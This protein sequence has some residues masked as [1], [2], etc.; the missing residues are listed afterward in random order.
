MELLRVE[1]LTKRY[2]GFSLTDVSFG[3]EEAHITGFIGRNGAG[4]TTTLKCIEGAVHPDAGEVF[5]FG[6][7]FQG[8]EAQVKRLTG[9]ALGAADFYR[10]KRLSRIANVTSRFYPNWNPSAFEDYCRRFGLDPN[11]RVKEL[12][13][14]MRVK[15]ALAL[16][17]SHGARLLVLDEPTSGLDP[18]SRAELLGILLDL[19]RNQGVGV[20]FSTHI[21]TDLEACAD[22]ILYLQDGTLIAQGPLADFEARYAV[23]PAS[24][25][26]ARGVP[27]LGLRRMATGETAL[28]SAD[29]QLG[30]PATL[31]D[32]MTHTP[33]PSPH[34]MPS[35]QRTI[36]EDTAL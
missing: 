33:H 13:Q 5:Y 16:A 34:A 30:K 9:F 28:V 24:S 11:K 21:T 19:A 32:I 7:P 2:P 27:I 1:G 35:G 25:A 10:T 17:L 18:V 36:R 6:Q 26:R 3:V 23:A 15:F 14:G 31:E 29:Y 8:H 20:L 22:E 12:S 4:K